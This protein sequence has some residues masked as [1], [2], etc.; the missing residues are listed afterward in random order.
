MDLWLVCSSVFSM[1]KNWPLLDIIC[2][3]YGL[4]SA[5]VVD[6]PIL[7]ILNV[8][9]SN[10]PWSDVSYSYK[11]ALECPMTYFVIIRI[12]IKMPYY[13]TAQHIYVPGTKNNTHPQFPPFPLLSKNLINM[14]S[15]K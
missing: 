6:F 14:G 1:H 7:C 2:L 5:F 11:W 8:T 13:L 3:F 4:K 9:A 15:R 12:G 10:R